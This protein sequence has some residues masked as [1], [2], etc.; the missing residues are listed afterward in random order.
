MSVFSIYY[1]PM[2]QALYRK[3][4]PTTFADVVDQTH[5]KT[6]L[7]NEIASKQFAHAY[8]FAGPRGVGKTTMAR[9]LAKAVNAEAI[10]KYKLVDAT[11]LDIIEIDAASHT[12]V[13]NVRDNVIQ[14]AYVAPTQLDYKVFIID[15]VHML[16][17][18]AFNA[19]LKILEEPPQHVIF[20]LATTEVHKIPATVI[21]RCQRFDFHA[22]RMP[23]IVKRLE[24]LCVQE[25]VTVAPVVLERIARKAGGAIR[26]AETMLGQVLSIGDANI[27]ADQA[28]LILPRVD[29]GIA[30]ELFRELVQRD[31]K[32]YLETLHKAV[33]EG[34][35]L[36]ELHTLLLD[37]LRRSLL[38]SVDQSLDHVAAL[39]V[40]AD[41]HM[42]L[43]EVMKQLSSRD[44]LQLVDLFI[45]AGEKLAVSSIPQ[46][47]L[48]AA[49]IAWCTH[50][51]AAPVG[52]SAPVKR[53]PS[54]V[55]P[56]PQK[57]TGQ[58]NPNINQTTSAVS[59]STI[60]APTTL[61]V[62]VTAFDHIKE[63]WPNIM[64]RV[65]DVNHSLAMALSVA[66]L[67]AVHKPQRLQL[68]FRYDFHKDRVCQRQHLT[69][70]QAILQE[71]TGLPY[72]IDCVVGEQYDVDVSLL[73]S[74]PS[75]NIAEINPAEVQN[76]WDLALNTIGGKEVK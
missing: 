37:I 40:H 54:Q 3:Y 62:D 42:Q 31:A 33:Q 71:V 21:S 44:C 56:P 47:P 4:R 52:D 2:S 7:L 63:T 41:T 72:T 69:S 45:A 66:H 43:V 22:I 6:T 49:G 26:D 67:V 28:D 35:Q 24:Y 34:V 16:S 30:L 59:A 75:D 32:P 58:K 76:V 20:I 8:L 1:A 5:I 29:I 53:L 61:E 60:N 12:G 13:D 74:L 9:L 38:Y 25:K 50:G 23:D 65:K 36:K 14:N 10:A 11:L 73:S 51:D 64:R 39:D 15:E 27:T 57:I 55:T 18:S 68:G 48:E 70:I 46:L 19:L 17:V